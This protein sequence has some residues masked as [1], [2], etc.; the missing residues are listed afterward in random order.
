MKN[1]D[2]TRFADW[3]FIHRARLNLVPLNGSTSWRSGD[4][5]CRRCGYITESLAHVVDHSM[6][7][8]GLYLA[9]HN[10]VITRIKNASSFG[11]LFKNQVC[12]SNGLRPDLVIRK[13]N[14]IT[15]IDVTIPFDNRMA[16]FISAA[17]INPCVRNCPTPMVR[18]HQ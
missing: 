6:R 13:N 9:R 7:Y 17:G 12:G 1:G 11:I 3:R 14:K 18:R 5:R 16:A 10:S 4:R 2:Y 15:I 8:S